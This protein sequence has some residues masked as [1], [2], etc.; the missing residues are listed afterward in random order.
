MERIAPTVPAAMCPLGGRDELALDL[1][2]ALLGAQALL[3]P[4]V[5]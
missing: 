1:D 5:P 3:S 2:A 4:G